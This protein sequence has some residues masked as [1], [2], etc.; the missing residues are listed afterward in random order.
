MDLAICFMSL[1]L[2]GIIVSIDNLT[3]ELSKIRKL[4]EEKEE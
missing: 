4:L 1:I 2:V 3:K